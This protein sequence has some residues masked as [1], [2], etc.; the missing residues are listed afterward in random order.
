MFSEIPDFFMSWTQNFQG[1]DIMYYPSY[2]NSQ[3]FE[4]RSA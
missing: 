3:A 2:H 1:Q 4:Y